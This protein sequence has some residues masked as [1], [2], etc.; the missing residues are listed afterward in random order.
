M[1]FKTIVSFIV[2]LM[3][4]WGII[5][6]GRNI[7]NAAE[8][9]LLHSQNDSIRKVNDS[10]QLTNNSIKNSFDS[11]YNSIQVNVTD[12]HKKDSIIIV[13]NKK[14]NEEHNFV[15]ALDATGVSSGLSNY[16]Q[17]KRKVISEQQRHINSNDCIG[18]EISTFR[19]NR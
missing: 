11:L 4:I 14:R 10:L 12:L 13:L 8:I 15:N 5:T 7:K 9:I 16:I 18:C 17:W 6:I 2:L 1:N 19:I 3:S